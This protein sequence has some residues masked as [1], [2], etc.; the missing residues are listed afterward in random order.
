MHRVLIPP[1]AVEG[2]TIRIDHPG[3]LHHLLRV[4]RVGVG[5]AV[6]CLDGRGR[7]YRGRVASRAARAVVVDVAE[8]TQDPPPRVAVT[9]AP[10]LLKPDRFDWLV[11]KATELGAC[12]IHPLVTARTVVRPAAERAARMTERWRRIAAE[13]AAQCGGSYL[14]DIGPPRRFDRYLA[15]LPDSCRG[16][17]PTLAVSAQPLRELLEADRRDDAAVV[18][19]IGPEGD[20][21]EEEVALARRHHARPVS[22]GPLTL[23]AETAALALLAMLQYALEFR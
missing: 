1:Q 6:E 9:L 3:A 13:A 21:T 11:Q 18:A 23:R 16:L 22:L 10:A 5:E 8:R 19:L 15:G 14:P 4:L 12:A 17:L 20:F 7:R 2:R